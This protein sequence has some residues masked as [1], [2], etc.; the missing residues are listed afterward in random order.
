MIKRDE[1]REVV[2]EDSWKSRNRHLKN[3]H[4]RGNKVGKYLATT[5]RKKKEENYI[6][7]IRNRKGESRHTSREIGE[8]FRQ[9]FMSL[10]SVGKKEK[11]RK[12]E[13]KMREFIK[14]AGLPSLLEAE[15]MELERPITQEE[16][17]QALKA[18]PTGKSPGPDGFTVSFFKKYKESLVPR[19][20]QL[21]NAMG[22]QGELGRDALLASVTLIPKE[23]KD[24]TLCS[25][26]RPISLL[27]ADTKLY[28]KVLALRLKEKMSYLIHPDQVGFVPG[29]EGRDNG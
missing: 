23:G 3:M 15:T 14:E 4:Q 25:S 10:Y 20:C 12:K 13:V 26:Y 16:I 24:R 7:K 1:L 28:A 27:N 17:M 18:T 21:W 6:E 11:C 29:R 19:L 2:A 22:K 9:Y 5:I 8:E